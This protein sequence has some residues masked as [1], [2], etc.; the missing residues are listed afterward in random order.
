VLTTIG[1]LDVL[2]EDPEQ[3]GV[4]ED[5]LEI[6]EAEPKRIA[7]QLPDQRTRK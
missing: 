7:P 5:V 1:P 6:W 2:L 4:A 3:Y